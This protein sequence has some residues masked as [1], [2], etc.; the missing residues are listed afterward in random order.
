MYVMAAHF[1][2][3]MQVNSHCCRVVMCYPAQQCKR[4]QTGNIHSTVRSTWCKRNSPFSCFCLPLFFH[5]YTLKVL[6]PVKDPQVEPVVE[7]YGARHTL[8]SPPLEGSHLVAFQ[9][10]LSRGEATAALLYHSLTLGDTSTARTPRFYFLL[11]S[12]RVNLA[13]YLKCISVGKKKKK[14]CLSQ[15]K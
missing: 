11:H 6:C 15:V 5:I 3:C 12:A 14:N 4:I 13:Y 7:M 2:G 9:E 10:L 8:V 1:T